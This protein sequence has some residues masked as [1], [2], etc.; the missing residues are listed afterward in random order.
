MQCMVGCL[1]Y[2]IDNLSHCIALSLEQAFIDSRFG[3]IKR[4]II[5]LR[6]NHHVLW[7]YSRRVELLL[8]SNWMLNYNQAYLITNPKQTRPSMNGAWI[9]S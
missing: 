6:Q 2:C 3:F 9:Y 4:L 8:S 7:S 1:F 5:F